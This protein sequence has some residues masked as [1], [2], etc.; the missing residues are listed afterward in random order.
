MFIAIYS[1]ELKLRKE[2]EFKGAWKALTEL[3]YQYEGSLGSRL[4]QESDDT[5]I[6]YAQWPDRE[7]WQNSGSNL[8]P[9]AEQYRTVMRESC[10]E[11]KTLHELEVIE[12]LL[13]DQPKP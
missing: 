6:A 2:S 7:T 13:K 4:H 11:I 10:K 3:I 9:S 8:P 12:D 1:F 5:Y